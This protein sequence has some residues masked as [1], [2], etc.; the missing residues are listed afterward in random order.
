LLG[1][2]VQCA[3]RHQEF[4]NVALRRV[5]FPVPLVRSPPPGLYVS[6]IHGC[7]LDRL[8][9]YTHV[10]SRMLTNAHVFREGRRGG[11]EEEG[12]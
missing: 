5:K 10:C 11:Q 3:D 12:R 4:E 9:T 8:L 2:L 7:E 1:A 6:L